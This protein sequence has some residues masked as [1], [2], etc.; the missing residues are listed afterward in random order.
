MTPLH[1]WNTA[2]WR[3]I[4]SSGAV[5]AAL[6]LTGP[7]GIGKATF[8]LAL[9]EALLCS[10]P[11]TDGMACSACAP[12]RLV[13]AGNHPDLRILDIGGSEEDAPADEAPV[14][15]SR[16]KKAASNWIRIEAVRGLRDFL[17]FTAHLGGRKVVLIRNADRLHPSAANALLKT[18]EEPSASTHFLLVTSHFTRLPATVRSRCVRLTFALP[19]A[20]HC[21]QWLQGQGLDQAEAA[22]AYAGG[23]PL[24]A[25]Q[26]AQP[27]TW[28][29][30]RRLI[31][32]I[33]AR[34]DFDAVQSADGLESTDLAPL[35]QA[36]Q[37]WCHDLLLASS[38]AAVRYHPDCARILHPIADRVSRTALVAYLRE[39]AQA[40]RT[41]EHPLNARLVAERCLI[42]YKTALRKES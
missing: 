35:I 36:L 33:L 39:L 7:A 5:P 40:A 21:I 12:C 42:G 3:G 34:P 15:E 16:E 6:L 13:A 27:E 23:A 38:A 37:R 17:A 24:R 14:K 28:A 1:P 18:L 10:D 11:S 29:F 30:R 8:G 41:V 25:L 2:I 19:D 26:L 9:A 32:S 31:D 22:L 20:G 4:A